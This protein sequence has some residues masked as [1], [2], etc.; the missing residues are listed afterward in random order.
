MAWLI[1]GDSHIW[2]F[3]YADE[4]GWIR[5]PCDFIEVMG[6]TAVG[7][8]NP[9]GQTNALEI[10]A[11]GLLPP[12]E[13]FTPVMQLG[14]VDC[15]FV[16]WWRAMKL[17]E[18]VDA[19]LETSIN[20]HF[21]FVDRLLSEGYS[22][23][24]LTGA[25]L[26]TIRDGQDWGEIANKRREVVTSLVERTQLTMRYNAMLR[27][28]AARRGLPFIDISS[29]IIDRATGVISDAFRAE[30]PLD[31]HLNSERAGRLWATALNA[32]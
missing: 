13:Q 31:H 32:L 26:P 15:G 18:S 12:R 11:Q 24:V 8:R 27:D 16:I 1:F 29:E 3:K 22:T 25:A 19:Q 23:V 28:G 17:A 4:K 7:L 5:Q 2:T 14:E 6:A 20:A 30:D 9:N 10:F 21:G